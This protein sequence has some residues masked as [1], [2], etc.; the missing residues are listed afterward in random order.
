MKRAISVCLLIFALFC[1]SA[2]SG[3]MGYGVVLWSIPE[4]GL[5]D[6][7][8]VPIYVR[9]NIGKVYIIGI[10]GSKQ[11]IEVPL[12]RITDPES[13]GKALKTAQRLAEYRRQYAV[14]ALD[15]LPIRT[16]PV[17]T[18]KRV[19]S[20][21]I[22]YGKVRRGVLDPGAVLVQL[23]PAI[24]SYA[25][26]SVSSG[27]LISE[28]TKGGNAEKAGLRGGTEAVQYA[29]GRRNRVVFYIGGDVITAINGTAV[30]GYADYYSLL[31][32]KK[33]GDSVTLT[34]QRGKKSERIT[35][36]LSEA[37]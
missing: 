26:L 20:D 8:V 5:F 11:K 12:W 28:L 33:P 22:Q 19:V 16:E 32:S 13:K 29:S 37:K 14:A 27:L 31:E 18:A 2:C 6:G 25:K 30:A 3:K 34:V 9:S 17:N 21:L 4:H 10:P 35:V 1:T 7:A 23:T 24:A 15:G 36:V